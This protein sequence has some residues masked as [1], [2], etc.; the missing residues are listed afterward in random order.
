MKPHR[1]IS[2]LF[3]L[4]FLA[5][6]LPSR[7]FAGTFLIDGSA[8]DLSGGPIMKDWTLV[9]LVD[10]YIELDDGEHVLSFDGP[11]GYALSLQLKV[12]GDLVRVVEVESRMRECGAEYDISWPKPRVDRDPVHRGVARIRLAKAHAKATGNSIPCPMY[13]LAS[14]EP[15]KIIVNITSEPAG[16][17]IWFPEG[18]GGWQK[19]DFR[20]NVTLSVPFCGYQSTKSVLV[21]MEGRLPCLEELPLSPDAKL[22]VTCALR[23]PGAAETAG[24]EAPAN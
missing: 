2:L 23:E 1:S 7:S 18:F 5:L 4:V 10:D 14:C 19:H 6:L 11:H 9:G 12:R 20:T 16:G 13:S 24:A 21:R 15:Q 8:A 3:S 17:E 22:I